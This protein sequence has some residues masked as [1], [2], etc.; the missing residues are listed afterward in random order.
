MARKSNNGA[1]SSNGAP[2]GFE[3]KLWQTADALRNNMDAPGKW[4]P[5]HGS[6][7]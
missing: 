1:G 7:A 5:V 4:K 6:R 3:A 2:L